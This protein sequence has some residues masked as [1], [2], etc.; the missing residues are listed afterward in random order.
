MRQI[1]SAFDNEWTPALLD[2]V[3]AGIE[4]I[5]VGE[6]NYDIYKNQI[7]I[8][9]SEGML[10]AYA[11]VGL[12]VMY[13]HWSFGKRYLSQSR[14]YK[15]GLMGLAYEIVI[16]SDPCIAYLMEANTLT[17]QTLVM[18]HACMG[19]NHFFKNNY[20]FKQW[21]DPDAIIDYLAYAKRYITRQEEIHGFDQVEIILDAAHTLS[22]Y[23][24]DKYNKRERTK[25]QLEADLKARLAWEDSQ[26]D[27]LVSPFRDRK[28]I[29]TDDDDKIEET[30][31][32]LYFIEKQAPNL[33]DWQREIIRI[34]RKLGQYFYPQRQTQVMNEGFAC[35]SH[36][37]IINELWDRGLLDERFMLEFIQSHSGVMGQRPIGLGDLKEINVYTLGF[38]MFR[39]IR[40]RC[41]N[42][43]KEDELLFPEQVGRPFRDVY[44]EAVRGYKDESFVL[45]YLSPQTVRDMRLMSLLDDDRNPTYEVSGI[46]DESSFEHV[47]M[48][49]SHHYDLGLA[50][51]HISI[52]DVDWKGNR[53]LKIRHDVHRRRPL[54]EAETRKILRQVYKLWQYPISIES[55]Y[56]D[57]SRKTLTHP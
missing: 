54:D 41:T 2:E 19:H 29:I 39:D 4:D 23:S 18:A 45:Q 49:L 37:E 3:Y 14:M 13:H 32:L 38:R 1:V 8:I 51:P 25:V 44:F 9:S 31:N 53:T 15:A 16:N 46:A 50:Q 47:R 5:A 36:Y 43:T 24:V 6:W 35:A 20:M 57:G 10:E 40:R 17:M 21:T 27:P 22:H 48:Q 26:Y 28:K 30:E 7:E 55:V 11:T 33:E 56:E 52:F 34:V 42:P 12:P